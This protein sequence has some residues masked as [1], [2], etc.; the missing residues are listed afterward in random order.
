MSAVH[1]DAKQ[2]NTTF[3]SHCTITQE[4]EQRKA[5][6][7][8]VTVPLSFY[9]NKTLPICL[10]SPKINETNELLD[11]PPMTQQ[12]NDLFAGTLC[13]HDKDVR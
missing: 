12:F 5:L 4:P 1:S 3:Q 10:M 9:L 13:K 11:E 8:T 2:T 6:E 7:M